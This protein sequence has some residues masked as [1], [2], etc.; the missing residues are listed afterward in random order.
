MQDIYTN[1]MDLYLQDS[2][3]ICRIFKKTNSSAHQRAISHHSWVSHTF[4]ETNI[5]QDNMLGSS[6][7][8]AQTTTTEFSGNNIDIPQT[9]A[10][11]TI[12]PIDYYANNS[13]K[14]LNPSM[15][16]NFKPFH[17]YFPIS[18]AGDY[19]NPSFTFSPLESPAAKCSLDVSSLLLN[20]SSSVLGDFGA[21]LASAESS[22]TFDFSSITGSQE[23]QCNNGFSSM[24]TLPHHEV[25]QG[26]QLSVVGSHDHSIDA[27]MKNITNHVNSNTTETDEHEHWETSLRS[28]SIGFPFM[29]SLPLI[30][31]NIAAGETWNKSSLTW[32]SSPCPSEMSTTRCYS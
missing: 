8:G 4:P 22:T 7:L 25:M 3:A 6:K 13:Y 24:T 23:Q 14:T 1:G 16:C 19:F 27:L 26:N 17:Q 2:W 31:L 32:D 20:M 18:N 9:T 29:G 11:S 21:K 15:A 30:P 12:S 10:T 28:S 5:F